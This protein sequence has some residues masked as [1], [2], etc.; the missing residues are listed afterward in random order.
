MEINHLRNKVGN[1]VNWFNQGLSKDEIYD[2]LTE[3]EVG[4]SPYAV[5]QPRETGDGPYI[6]KYSLPEDGSHQLS[7]IDD[8]EEWEQA[9][10]AFDNW[11]FEYHRNP[12]V[13]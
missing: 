13:Q 8:D 11:L 4:G 7:P 2:V 6:F 1:E 5:V 3:F 10:E 9:A 12:T